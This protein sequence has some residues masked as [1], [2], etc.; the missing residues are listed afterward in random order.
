MPFLVLT[1]ETASGPVLIEQARLVANSVDG[2]IIPGSGHWLME[3]ATGQV[4]PMIVEFLQ[5]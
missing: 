5:P 2:R 4:I 3:E 1:G